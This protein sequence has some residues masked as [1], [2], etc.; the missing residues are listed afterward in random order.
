VGF[1]Q[2][3]AGVKKRRKER[4]R[5]LRNKQRQSDERSVSSL[6]SRE[7][8][9]DTQFYGWLGESTPEERIDHG[10]VMP[11][12]FKS[13]IALALVMGSYFLMQTDSERS[14]LIITKQLVYDVLHQDFN[15]QGVTAWYNRQAKH[16]H[17]LPSFTA[18]GDK[19]L[20]KQEYVVPV[21][22]GNVTRYAAAQQGLVI[23]TSRSL[24]V[25]V[26]KEG[27]VTFVGQKEGVGRVVVIDHGEGEEAWYGQLEDIQ[28]E[29]YDWVEQG[30]V[31]GYTSVHAESGEGRFYFA[32]RRDSVFI[33]PLDVISFD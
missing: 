12:I 27:W 26:V 22:S 18:M 25:E 2:Y 14:E 24:P 21:S 8:D 29:Q 31:I 20:E 19:P 3:K 30:E 28:V 6:R 9:R 13:L 17:F 15:I 10:G 4:L 23:G 33:D 7:W 16:V 5:L 11:I 32:L 1:K